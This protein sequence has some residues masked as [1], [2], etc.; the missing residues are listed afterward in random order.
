MANAKIHHMVSLEDLGLNEESPAEIV[1][2]TFGQNGEPHASTIGVRACGKSGVALEVFTDTRTFKNLI[3][4]KAAVINV[5]RDAG[6]LAYLALKNLLRFKYELNFINSK[7]V[8]APRLEGADAFVEIEV[9][10]MRREKIS[11]TLGTSEVA[12]FRA[13]I[14]HIDIRVS[15][16]RPFKRSE[17]FVIESAVLA[18]KVLEAMKRG[19]EEI[20]SKLFREIVEYREKCERVASGSK[21]S[22]IIAEIVGSL[23]RRFN[24][25]G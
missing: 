7:Y 9:K 23:A 16:A 4:S 14:K 11:N 25:R 10:N 18:T 12:H 5:V 22:R 24:W 20:A 1:L 13:K 17:A 15:G 3:G 6:I 8:N 19:K 21:D 2:T